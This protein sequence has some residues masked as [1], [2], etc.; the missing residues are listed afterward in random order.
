[1]KV[2]ECSPFFN[3]NLI[4]K[5]KIAEA[6]TWVDELHIIEC[7]KSFRF[8]DKSYSFE[9]ADDPLVHYHQLDGNAVFQK[10]HWSLSFSPW[11]IKQ[12]DH[13]WENEG[14]QRNSACS[15][16]DVDDNDIVILSDVDEIIDSRYAD[17]IIHETRK[18]GIVTI[19]LHFTLFYFN[20]FSKNWGGPPSYSYRTF[21]MTGRYFKSMY[22][23]SDQLRKKGEHG[24]LFSMVYCL[25][26]IMGFHHSWL[27]DDRYVA[28]KL[29]SYSHDATDHDSRV[30]SADGSVNVD[31]IRECIEQKRSVFGPEHE[32]YADHTINLLESVEK[33][34]HNNKSMYFI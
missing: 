5:I 30:F 10:H 8:G 34:K 3:E 18:C 25:E 6:R 31:Y 21:I 33:L 26:D 24:K 32:L 7:N 15:Y 27:G 29:K 14:R 22:I 11:F 4:A 19:K 12:Q 2:V 13:P 9:F 16:I 23:T 1:M 28:E 17:R 20:L